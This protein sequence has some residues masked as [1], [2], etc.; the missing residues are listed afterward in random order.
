M[1][2]PGRLLPVP[3]PRGASTALRFK[4]CSA[5]AVCGPPLVE[6]KISS[7]LPD[8]TV[9]HKNGVRTDNRVV[10]LQ[11]RV[12]MHGRGGDVEEVLAWAREIVAR[13]G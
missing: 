5:S 9:H 1:E 12:G 2:P 3:S 6:S 8:E 10:N 11:L 13:Y 7:L 4:L